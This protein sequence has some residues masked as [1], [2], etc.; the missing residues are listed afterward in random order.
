MVFTAETGKKKQHQEKKAK[1]LSHPKNR[2]IKTMNQYFSTE[3]KSSHD[4]FSSSPTKSPNQPSS[5]LP[6]ASTSCSKLHLGA[7]Q[8]R[9]TAGCFFGWAWFFLGRGVGFMSLKKRGYIHVKQ[10]KFHGGRRKTQHFLHEN[11]RKC[12]RDL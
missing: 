11:W 7:E 8:E 10:P 2:H 5:K 4:L 12:P 1:R 6:T 9:Q 3:K